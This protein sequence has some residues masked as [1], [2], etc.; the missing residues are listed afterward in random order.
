MKKLF[1][2][3]LALCMAVSLAA[4][5]GA[6]NKVAG[7]WTGTV[8]ATEYLLKETPELDGY[9]KNA[10][11]SIT[12]ELT[13][14]GNYTMNTDATTIIPAF[15]E[16]MRSYF[17]AYCEE[18]GVT[19]EQLEEAMKMTLDELI[20]STFDDMDTG[21]LTETVTGAYSVSEG[22]IVFDPG[23]FARVDGVWSG[24][25]MSFTIDIGDVTLYR[26]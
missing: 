1:A 4:C 13:A 24:D 22:K 12:L 19:V 11:V 5:G 9:L 26:K 3:L 10:P 16:A 23:S 8:D 14:D 21:D 2:L 7:T 25:M 15:K 17:V 6:G 20:D 18:Q